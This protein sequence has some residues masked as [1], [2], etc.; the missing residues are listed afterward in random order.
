[1][2][3]L[4]D[5]HGRP[6]EREYQATARNRYY[7]N[8]VSTRG[9]NTELDRAQKVLYSDARWLEQNHDLAIALLDEWVSGVVGGTLEI[10]PLPMSRGGRFMETFAGDIMTLFEEGWAKRPEVTWQLHWQQVIRTAARSYARD[11]EIFAR[12]IVGNRRTAPWAEGDIPYM[13]QPL[14]A[15]YCDHDLYRDSDPTIINGVELNQW[16]KPRA[17]HLWRRHPEESM[18]ILSRQKLERRRIPAEEIVHY[19]HAKRFGQVRGVSLFH[20]ISTRLRDVKDLEESE[21]IAARLNAKLAVAIERHP[22]L[23]ERFAK[24]EDFA[25]DA[26]RDFEFETGS[27][28]DDLLPGETVRGI[29]TARPNPELVPYGREQLRRICAGFGAK[30]SNVAR[31]WSGSYSSQRQELVEMRQ[32][33]RPSREELINRFIEPIYNMWLNVA[34]ATGRL[35]VPRNADR[36]RVGLFEVSA[37]PIPWIQPAQEIDAAIKERDAGLVSN[38]T[39]MRERG[40]KRT[41]RDLIERERE[42]RGNGETSEPETDGAPAQLELVASDEGGRALGSKLQLR[43]AGRAER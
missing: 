18:T 7:P 29:E 24:R 6:L 19:R 8:L 17:F 42:E 12:H 32:S 27:I 9:P 31:D 26:E 20:G 38:E 39:L 33:Y 40:R 13:I 22:E 36:R 23:W 4:V 14:E 1:M 28:W 2:A 41:E 5:I 34:I 21:R 35:R 10:I 16:G 15:D 30:Y 11:G 43:V 37:S 3:E 25:I